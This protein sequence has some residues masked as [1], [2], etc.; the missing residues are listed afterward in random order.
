MEFFKQFVF[1]VFNGNFE[2]SFVLE[3]Q[4]FLYFLFEIRSGSYFENDFRECDPRLVFFPFLFPVI[5]SK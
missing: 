1:P 5:L 2:F 4:S 3:T